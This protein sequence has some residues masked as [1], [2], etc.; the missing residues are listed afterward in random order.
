MVQ[1]IIDDLVEPFIKY[2]MLHMVGETFKDSEKFTKSDKEALANL[3]N[4]KPPDWAEIAMQ[5][6]HHEWNVVLKQLHEGVTEFR[7]S[8]GKK[9]S[10]AKKL[11]QV[12]GWA[13]ATKHK[14]MS[15]V[16]REKKNNEIKNK[17]TANICKL[18]IELQ[19]ACDEAWSISWNKDELCNNWNVAMNQCAKTGERD[20][21]REF[22]SW[23]LRRLQSQPDE[24]RPQSVKDEIEKEKKKIKQEAEKKIFDEKLSEAYGCKIKDQDYKCKSDGV[25]WTKMN[26]VATENGCGLFGQFPCD[27]KF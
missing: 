18:A 26:G 22:P 4:E 15:V 16:E 7:S 6:H 10:G 3:V 24:Q 25:E 12:A 27:C 8:H 2:G 20:T 21:V 1:L 23:K 5:K 11:W 19:T 14:I 9:I 13:A 17:C